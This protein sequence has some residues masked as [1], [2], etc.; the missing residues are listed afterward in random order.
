[1]ANYNKGHEIMTIIKL[2]TDVD[3]NKWEMDETSDYMTVTQVKRYDLKYKVYMKRMNT[4]DKN[5]CKLYSL[6]LGQCT[7]TMQA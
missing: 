6:V 3:S 5:K 4:L 7:E 1:M 2:I